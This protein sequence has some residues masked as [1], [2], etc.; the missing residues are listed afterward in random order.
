MQKGLKN[1]CLKSGNLL[2]NLEDD[3]GVGDQDP[4]KSNNQKP[5][6]L[7]SSILGHSKRLLTN[8]FH[9]NNLYYGDTDSGY[10]HKKRGVPQLKKVSLVYLLDGKRSKG[11]N[12]YGIA[13]IF[14][15]GFLAPK[16]NIPWSLTITE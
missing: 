10:I 16:K 8:G 7:R 9:S 3:A 5:C 2:V 1:G 4:A 13:N 14:Y 12:D 11:K 15:V 6:H